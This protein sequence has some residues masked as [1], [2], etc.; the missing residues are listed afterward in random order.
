MPREGYRVGLPYAG[1]W[2]EVINTDAEAY[3]GSGVGN[4]G[5]VEA[6]PVPHHARPASATVRVPPLG[7]VWLRYRPAAAG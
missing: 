3:F 4:F 5:G 1:R 2:D 6:V 7:A